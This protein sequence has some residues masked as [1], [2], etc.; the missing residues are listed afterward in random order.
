MTGMLA[1][2]IGGIIPLLGMI[3][4]LPLL[5]IIASGIEIF[6]QNFLTGVVCALL[7]GASGLAP[8]PALGEASSQEVLAA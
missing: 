7:L 3:G 1:F 4:T 5:L 8:S 2:V 6:F